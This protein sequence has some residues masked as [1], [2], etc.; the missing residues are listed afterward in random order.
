MDAQTSDNPILE[1]W[2]VDAGGEIYQGSFDELTQWIAEGSLLPQDKVRRGNLRWIE[3]QK[4]PL[5]LKFFNAKE[6][7]A[8][9]PVVTTNSPTP[10][11]SA[12]SAP[13]INLDQAKFCLVHIETE[14]KFVCDGC[15]NFFCKECPSSFGAEVKI[16]PMCGAM[17]KDLGKAV[18]V[19]D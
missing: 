19:S 6:L 16:C 17:C 11:P 2:Q 8:V 12:V 10:F 1:I 13:N 15:T 3:A 14:A 7:G 18:K 4:V 9:P 5:F